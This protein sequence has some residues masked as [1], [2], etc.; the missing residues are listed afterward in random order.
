MM[1]EKKES[2][3]SHFSIIFFSECLQ[4]TLCIRV[5]VILNDPVGI[6]DCHSSRMFS[7]INDFKAA[8]E[9]VWHWVN[10]VKGRMALNKICLTEN[11]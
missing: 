11:E 2:G 5:N 7:S 1:F 6:S 4:Y 3:I 9:T 8:R 10:F